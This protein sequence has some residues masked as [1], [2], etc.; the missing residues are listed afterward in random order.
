MPGI[1]KR[2]HTGRHAVRSG[3][4]RCLPDQKIGVW[5]VD[6]LFSAHGERRDPW[7]SSRPLIG[8]SGASRLAMS[9][10]RSAGA[11]PNAI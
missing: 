2:D 11:G 7:F 1:R 8:D 6:W 10:C 5:Q 9:S 4:E 3:N